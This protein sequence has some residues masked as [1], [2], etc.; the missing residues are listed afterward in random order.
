VNQDLGEATKISFFPQ[1]QS[2]AEAEIK[3]EEQD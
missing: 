2:L 1:T 3:P